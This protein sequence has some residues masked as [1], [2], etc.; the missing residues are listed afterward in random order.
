MAKGC[1][2]SI[3]QTQQG[4]R[5][6]YRFCADSSV[7]CPGEVEAG[8]RVC[9]DAEMILW[10]TYDLGP[11]VESPAQPSVVC[12]EGVISIMVFATPDYFVSLDTCR[13]CPALSGDECLQD[14][15]DFL[16]QLQIYQGVYLGPI[17]RCIC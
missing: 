4:T 6:C 8:C 17:I 12:G 5:F 14:Y 1:H 10:R 16:H 7:I 15:I 3:G 13:T 2:V 9:I 11:C